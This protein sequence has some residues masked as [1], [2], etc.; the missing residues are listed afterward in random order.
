MGAKTESKE[1]I[2]TYD[3]GWI[4]DKPIVYRANWQTETPGWALVESR[5]DLLAEFHLLHGRAVF[6]FFLGYQLIG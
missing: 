3:H 4:L 2:H 6:F 5:C 1:K